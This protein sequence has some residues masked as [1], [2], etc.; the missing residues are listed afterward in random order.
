MPPPP[1]LARVDSCHNACAKDS[2]ACGVSTCVDVE[3]C[4]AAAARRALPGGVVR[5]IDVVEAVVGRGCAPRGDWCAL[6]ALAL[7]CARCG[8]SEPQRVD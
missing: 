2:V 4:V 3:T 6:L 5:G 7:A 1:P 8:L